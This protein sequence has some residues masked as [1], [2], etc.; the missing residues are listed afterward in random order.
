[1]IFCDLAGSVR[2]AAEKYALQELIHAHRVKKL[3][4]RPPSDA[5]EAAESTDEGVEETRER[6]GGTRRGSR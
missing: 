6:E 1:M 5:Q 4:R 3:Q 2:G